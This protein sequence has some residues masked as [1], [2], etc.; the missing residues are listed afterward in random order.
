M[1]VKQNAALF[2]EGGVP[3]ACQWTSTST[4]LYYAMLCQWTDTCTGTV[5]AGN[6]TNASVL[7]HVLPCYAMPA[8]V[9]CNN[10]SWCTNTNA[11]AK[12]LVLDSNKCEGASVLCS[13]QVLVVGQCVM[14]CCVMLVESSKHSTATKASWKVLVCNCRHEGATQ[15]AMQCSSASVL[16]CHTVLKCQ[17]PIAGASVLVCH[18]VCKCQCAS[19]LVLVGNWRCEGAPTVQPTIC[20]LLECPLLTM[21]RTAP[22]WKYQYQQYQ[23]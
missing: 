2:T 7:C 22:R 12:V 18:T 16:V 17:W 1:R 19:V 23:Y 11:C 14:L 4:V 10:R 5:L 3:A 8:Q 6:I 13:V 15:C 20:Q 21:L 9:Q